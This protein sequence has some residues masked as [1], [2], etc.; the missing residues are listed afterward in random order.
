[1]SEVEQEVDSEVVKTEE[2]N[3]SSKSEDLVGEPD[4]VKA[5]EPLPKFETAE[6]KMI[7][8]EQIKMLQKLINTH[9]FHAKYDAGNRG[10]QEPKITASVQLN[11]FNA[12]MLQKWGTK[13]VELVERLG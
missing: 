6:E 12:Q 5:P 8:M 10:R 13:I 1:M 11:F 4:V 3:F 7:A 2:L 9:Y